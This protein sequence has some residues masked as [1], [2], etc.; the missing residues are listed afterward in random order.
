MTKRPAM[1]RESAADRR[2]RARRIARKLFAA[3]P[4]ATIALHFRN[5]FELICATVLSAQC[6]D[7]RVNRTTP[8]LFAR[9]PDAQAMAEAPPEELEQLIRSTG[10]YK[11][12]ARSLV[13]LAKAI[14]TEHRGVVP[15]TMEELVELPGVGRKTANVV[16]GNAYD[17]PGITVDTH[18][19]RVSARLELT[20]DTDPVRIESDLMALIARADWTRFS[21]AMIFHGRRICVARKPRCAECPL[22][23]DCPF[24]KRTGILPGPVRGARTNR[25]T[26][27]QLRITPDKKILS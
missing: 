1:P 24:P 25:H 2:K 14:A 22:L 13:G 7:E 12:K 15:G 4:D 21:H 19:S 20:D 3:H 23:D 11:S 17:T 9:F 18:V 6:T 26:T 5:P 16:L 10:F 27:S 8:A